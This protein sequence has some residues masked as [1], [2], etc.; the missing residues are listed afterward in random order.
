MN[1]GQKHCG[2]FAGVGKTFALYCTHEA[3]HG[4]FLHYS[5]QAMAVAAA[6]PRYSFQLLSL[7]RDM[8]YSSA[9]RAAPK[10]QWTRSGTALKLNF[11]GLKLSKGPDSASIG[12]LEPN[13]CDEL[14]IVVY[15]E[16]NSIV[17]RCGISQ[18]EGTGNPYHLQYERNSSEYQQ[19]LFSSRLQSKVVCIK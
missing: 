14:L 12:R 18:W 2:G 16:G 6:S 9:G 8:I 10:L 13:K 7:F 17:E 5:T 19:S 3:Q 1:K 4:K 11:E 15:S